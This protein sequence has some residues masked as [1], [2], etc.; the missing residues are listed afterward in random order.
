[1]QELC[2]VD[3]PAYGAIFG[4]TI[5]RSPAILQAADFMHLGLEFELAVEVGR[6]VPTSGAPYDR[7]KIAPHVEACMPAFELIEDRSR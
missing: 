4:R 3:R 1:V 7:E 5:R 2:G 6:D